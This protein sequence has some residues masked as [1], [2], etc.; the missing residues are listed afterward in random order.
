[1]RSRM[2]ACDDK[3]PFTTAL[4]RWLS[5]AAAVVS[6]SGVGAAFESAS[7]A[8]APLPP[9]RSRDTADTHVDGVHFYWRCALVRCA[10]PMN[11]LLTMVRQQS[12]AC[13]CAFPAALGVPDGE[14][15]GA[16]ARPCP[17][18]RRLL[19]D[20]APPKPGYQVRNLPSVPRELCK[21]NITPALPRNNSVQ[22][23]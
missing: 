1:M 11:V 23:K 3:H 17:S 20:P 2:R 10:V 9:T 7:V 12:M 16:L 8:A 18:P 5:N 6:M 15:P 21:K 13:R 14:R 19:L 22:S 4:Q